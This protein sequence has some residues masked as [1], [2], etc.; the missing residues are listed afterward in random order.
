MQ[1]K[2]WQVIRFGGYQGLWGGSGTQETQVS[3]PV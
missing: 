1:D 2:H 3:W